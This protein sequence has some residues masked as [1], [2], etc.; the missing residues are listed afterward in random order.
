MYK[1]LLIFRLVWFG[2]ILLLQGCAAQSQLIENELQTVTKENLRYYLYYPK[3]Y[4]ANEDSEYGILLFLHGGGEA[5]GNLE[6]IKENGPP[7]LLVEGKQFPF[8]VLAPQNPHEK[9]WWN[10]EAVVQLLDSVIETNRVDK[11]R[12]YLTGLSRGGNAAWELATQYPDKFAA[13]AVV[14]GMAPLPYAHWI[15]KEMPIWVFHGAKD[16][17]IQVSESDEMVAKLKK[18]G[19]QVKYTRYPNVGHNAWEKAYTTES[20]YTWFAQQKRVN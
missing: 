13:L 11:N 10:T 8:L 15:D 9:K 3:G 17:V 2:G 20:L 18:M 19:Y 6:Q 14:C 4:E 1:S 16:D 7:K 5:G 12:I